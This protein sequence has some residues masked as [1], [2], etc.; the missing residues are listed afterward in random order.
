M[1]PTEATRS[2]SV[3][4][5]ILALPILVSTFVT[6]SVDIVADPRLRVMGWCP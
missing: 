4:I 3:V 2:M 6:C 5:A 1:G